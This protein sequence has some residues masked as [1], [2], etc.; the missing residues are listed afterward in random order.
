MPRLTPAELQ[1]AKKKKQEERAKEEERLAEEREIQRQRAAEQRAIRKQ[2][3]AEEQQRKEEHAAWLKQAKERLEQLESVAGTLYEEV[4]KLARKWPTAS[5]SQM[6]VDKTNKLIVAVRDLLKNEG[7][8][9]VEDINVIVPAGDLPESRDVVIIL[10]QIRAALHRFDRK[11]W[12]P[13]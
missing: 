7:D 2:Q 11:Y 4:D 3:E 5:S 13:Y 12:R 10:S 1:A 6:I 9:F 8:E